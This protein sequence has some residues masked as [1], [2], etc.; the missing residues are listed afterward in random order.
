MAI[1]LAYDDA[2]NSQLINALVMLNEHAIQAT[3]YLLSDTES[4]WKT[5]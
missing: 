3:F 5:A 2:L 4:V 1:T